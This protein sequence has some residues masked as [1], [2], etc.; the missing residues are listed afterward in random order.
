MDSVSPTVKADLRGTRAGRNLRSARSTTARVPD[1][2]SRQMTGTP[3]RS[4]VFLTAAK[5]VGAR[6]PRTDTS[7]SL[8]YGSR[9]RP[10]DRVSPSTSASGIC[11]ALTQASTSSV[12]PTFS[13]TEEG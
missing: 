1:P 11:P 3:A 4:A 10:R 7:S 13:S 5:A 12:L 2:G 6:A 9:D 8:R